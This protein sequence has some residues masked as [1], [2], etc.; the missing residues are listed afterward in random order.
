MT[1]ASE[2]ASDGSSHG[3]HTNDCDLAFKLLIIFL[4]HSFFVS[5]PRARVGFQNFNCGPGPES[6]TVDRPQCLSFRCIWCVMRMICAW[7]FVT[8]LYCLTPGSFSFEGGLGPEGR[9]FNLKKT[10]DS[11]LSDYDIMTLGSISKNP[12]VTLLCNPL[13]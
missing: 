3:T 6:R 9:W 12:T 10:I 5:S 4:L 13:E 2:S 11:T 1:T 8:V 7:L